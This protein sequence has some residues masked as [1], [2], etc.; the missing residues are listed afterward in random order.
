MYVL[1][2]GVVLLLVS[3]VAVESKRCC[4]FKIRH[5]M[6]YLKKTLYIIT[7]TLYIIQDM[8]YII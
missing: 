5:L 4:G 2:A 1:V 7:D 8:I 6:K 3:G